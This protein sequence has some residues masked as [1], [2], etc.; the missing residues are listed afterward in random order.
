LNLGMNDE[1]VKVI[2]EKSGTEKFA[3]DS[4]R[5]FIQMYGDVV[6]GVEAEEGEHRTP[7]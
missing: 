1:T 6:M 5:R 7:G 2:A 3:Y 4:S